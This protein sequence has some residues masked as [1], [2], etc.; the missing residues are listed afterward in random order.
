[1]DADGGAPPAPS[2]AVRA[3]LLL[4]HR[5]GARARGLSRLLGGSP[6]GRLDLRPVRA[7]GARVQLHPAAAGAL[8]AHARGG[9]TGWS[10]YAM[11]YPNIR[12]TPDAPQPQAARVTAARPRRRYRPC[13]PASASSCLAAPPCAQPARRSAIVPL[14]SSCRAAN[15]RLRPRQPQQ[16]PSPSSA[17]AVP[18]T[19]DPASSPSAWL[20]VRPS[21]PQRLSSPTVL[22]PPAAP[23][24]SPVPARLSAPPKR[25]RGRH[26]VRPGMEH[27]SSG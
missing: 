4:P 27:T 24:A 2:R 7:P 16:R 22:P 19:H 17:V 14:P 13:P 1:M 20:F 26:P 15:A 18:T 8:P 6:R 11:A 25:P 12:P 9:P 3:H 23:E 10:G 5:H 21:P